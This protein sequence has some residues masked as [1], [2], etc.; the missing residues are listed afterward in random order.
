MGCYVNPPKGTKEEWL[1]ENGVLCNSVHAENVVNA[2]PSS[3]DDDTLFVVVLVKNPGFSAA[4]VAYCASEY[5]V[6]TDPNDKRPKKFYTVP[7][8]KLKLVSDVINYLA[9]TV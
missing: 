1:R 5:R 8:G 7:L 3:P 6:F 4:G 9:E 2:Y